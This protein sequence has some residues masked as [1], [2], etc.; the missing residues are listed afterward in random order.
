VRL[1]QQTQRL[2]DLS[3]RLGGAMHAR[4]QHERLRLAEL[5]RRLM[6]RS[7]DRLLERQRSRLQD[8]Q[9]RL[10]HAATGR[11][12]ASVQRLALAQRGLNAVSPLA[13]LARG[14]AI[15]TRADGTLVTDA[16]AVGTGEE[17]EAHL[18]RG[19]LTARVTAR[20]EKE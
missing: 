11:M 13:T 18:A 10:R 15:V 6:H 4:A 16:A 3:V 19:S 20:R 7:P 2:D 14:F 8:L 9:L 12:A 17:I 1:E 5:H